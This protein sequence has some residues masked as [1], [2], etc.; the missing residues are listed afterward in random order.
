MAIASHP[1]ARGALRNRVAFALI[2]TQLPRDR[3]PIGSVAQRHLAVSPQGAHFALQ[4]TQTAFVLTRRQVSI[5]AHHHALAISFETT[6]VGLAVTDGWRM[7]DAAWRRPTITLGFSQPHILA[8]DPPGWE[9]PPIELARGRLPINVFW[10]THVARGFANGAATQQPRI[11][12]GGSG[13]R[14]SRVA[15]LRNGLLRLVERAW[16]RAAVTL[17]DRS[18]DDCPVGGV[19]T[20]VSVLRG[21]CA[22]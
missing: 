19:H 12:S 14:R 5:G 1:F 21:G 20:N 7:I 15:G 4:L 8:S 3:T 11:G 18:A 10:G 22:D 17:G 13:G 2:A 16:G 9:R 6:P